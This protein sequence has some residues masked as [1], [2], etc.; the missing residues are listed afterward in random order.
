MEDPDLGYVDLTQEDSDSDVDAFLSSHAPRSKE[1]AGS[2][3]PSSAGTKR[4]RFPSNEREGKGRA[5]KGAE[6]KAEDRGFECDTAVFCVSSGEEEE[7]EDL[8]FDTSFDG[9]LDRLDQAKAKAESS[10]TPTVAN[11]NALVRKGEPCN[12]ASSGYDNDH[13]D[14][15]AGGGSGSRSGSDDD[16][17]DVV[18]G[19]RQRSSSR[20]RKHKA[21]GKCSRK[22]QSKDISDIKGSQWTGKMVAQ[23]NCV[24]VTTG[25]A[26]KCT[27]YSKVK[28]KRKAKPSAAERQ[29]SKE[30][31]RQDRGEY[32]YQEI[33][34]IVENTLSLGF[35][36]PSLFGGPG[37]GSSLAQGKANGGGAAKMACNL[38]PCDETHPH[39]VGNTFRVVPRAV[40]VVPGAVWWRRRRWHPPPAPGA[41]GNRGGTKLGNISELTAGCA[42]V[43][44]SA[45]GLADSRVV[46]EEIEW[47]ALLMPARRFLSLLTHARGACAVAATV[48]WARREHERVYPQAYFAQQ[49]QKHMGMFAQP[50]C[51]DK[52]EQ[53]RG[54]RGK[55]VRSVRRVRVADCRVILIVE[56]VKKEITKR[57]FRRNGRRLTM[58]DVED[59]V[60][61]LYCGSGRREEGAARWSG[62]GA[63]G[64]VESAGALYCKAPRGEGRGGSRTVFLFDPV[65]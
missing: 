38:L 60:A 62:I 19:K 29:L 9:L 46:L 39:A 52:Q 32:A 15:S 43:R 16:L 54:R 50:G 34:V 40:H 53:D 13:A 41:N 64:A 27:S 20:K 55:G 28:G 24:A 18:Y 33:E 65:V 17:E 10:G 37:L 58:D 4:K 59:A 61:F 36:A 26:G 12:D 63:A 23:R 31:E 49:R 42:G 30:M 5:R 6:G 21:R 7:E 35:N 22:S 11:K 47:L 45:G 25:K 1:P 8:C 57:V 14:G 2:S 56:G 3:M 44:A 48:D 51:G